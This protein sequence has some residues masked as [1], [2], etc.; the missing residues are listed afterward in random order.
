MPD[1]HTFPS[2]PTDCNLLYQH[3]RDDAYTTLLNYIQSSPKTWAIDIETMAKPGFVSNVESLTSPQTADIRL[4]Q[5]YDGEKYTIVLD[6]KHIPGVLEDLARILPSKRLLAHN[7]KFELTFLRANGID[8]RNIGCTMIMRKILHRAEYA[9]FDTSTG[10]AA[11]GGRYGFGPCVL[12]YLG[13][14]LS[15]D[16]DHTGWGNPSMNY[17]QLSYAALDAFYLWHIGEIMA[18]Q[19]VGYGFTDAYLI[20]KAVQHSVVAM[21]QEGVVFDK[22]R[23]ISLVEKWKQSQLDAREE[24]YNTIPERVPISKPSQVR[25]LIEQYAPKE[26]LEYWPKTATGQISLSADVLNEY[27]HIPFIAPFA[28]FTKYKS[29]LSKYGKKMH[30]YIHPVSQKMHT[31][32]NICGAVTGRF[33]SKLPNLQ[34]IPRGR[35][36][37]RI[38]TAKEGEAIICADYGQIELRVAAIHSGDPTMLDCF[39]T[40]KDIHRL[41][42]SAVARVSYDAVTKEQ[43]TNAKAVN[44]GFIYGMGWKKFVAYAKWT[45]GVT[46]T[47]DEAKEVKDI[48]FQTYSQYYTWMCAQAKLCE[49]LQYSDTVLGH[50]RALDEGYTYTAGINHP[51]QGGAGHVLQRALIRLEERYREH[52]ELNARLCLTVHDEISTY[53][54]LEHAETVK[55][56]KEEEMI[57]GYLD[58]FPSGPTTDLVEAHIGPDWAEAK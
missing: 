17:E 46:F 1:R 50:R 57:A 52:P 54:P 16:I 36:V 28:V 22:E 33:S 6:C 55:A 5:L 43:R 34:N 42:G 13:V 2:V 29:L 38:F 53:C 3:T 15:K 9:T 49:K 11:D 25:S 18:K 44:F 30:D 20:Q 51:I 4:V 26:D 39:H 10:G 58:I 40:G 23:H 48:F 8:I 27:M 12:H 35:D 32:F 19:I 7:A 56:I 14:E 24:F 21:E 31:T 45:Y 37:R 47:E 41:T